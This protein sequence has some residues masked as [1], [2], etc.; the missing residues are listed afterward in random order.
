V[1]TSSRQFRLVSESCFFNTC[2]T[3]EAPPRSMSFW[4]MITTGEAV[5]GMRPRLTFCG[6]REPVRTTFSWAFFSG[7]TT[8]SFFGSFLATVSSLANTE[9]A[10]RKSP[11]HKGA[12]KT[13]RDCG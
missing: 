3:V 5:A 2:A 1:R 8:A 11:A 9:P 10:S 6:M 7:F 13:Q 12:T 4:S